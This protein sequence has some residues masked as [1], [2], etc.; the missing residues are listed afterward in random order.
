MS[1]WDVPLASGS[2]PPRLVK[3]SDT[4]YPVVVSVSVISKSAV[5]SPSPLFRTTSPI[6][7]DDGATPSPAQVSIG[8]MSDG[9]MDKLGMRTLAR[10]CTDDPISHVASAVVFGSPSNAPQPHVTAAVSRRRDKEQSFDGWS[11]WAVTVAVNVSAG[12]NG[13]ISQP[14]T[15]APIETPV[16]AVGLFEESNTK[17]APSVSVSRIQSAVPSPVF[18]TVIVHVAVS[19]AS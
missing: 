8:V 12:A 13:P 16:P 7:P 17:D 3:R 14:M 18:S 15:L 9:E 10:S 4:E 2:V 1:V 6:S 11:R 5:T 19:E